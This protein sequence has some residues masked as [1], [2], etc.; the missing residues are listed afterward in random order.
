MELMVDSQSMPMN[1][2]RAPAPS[3]RYTPGEQGGE[4]GARDYEC[5]LIAE[6]IIGACSR[7]EMF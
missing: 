3:A 7:E 1:N 4:G 5:S 2:R 6:K